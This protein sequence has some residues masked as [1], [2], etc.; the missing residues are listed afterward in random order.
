[1]KTT[2]TKEYTHIVS[3]ENS[4]SD[5]IKNFE[6]E[7]NNYTGKNLII[8][9]SE[10]YNTTNENILLFLKYAHEHQDNGTS[11]VIIYKDVTIDDF[12]DTF[13]IVPTLVEAEDVIEMENIQRDLGF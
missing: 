13:N 2:H 10:K 8:Q 11:F 9:I 3:D 4:F 5:F 1:M 7:Y 6:N 12:P